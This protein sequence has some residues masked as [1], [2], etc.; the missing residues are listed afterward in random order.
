[1]SRPGAS[2]QEVSVQINPAIPGTLTR[3]ASGADLGAPQI[4]GDGST[5]VYTRFVDNQWDIFKWRD[6]AT[7]AV[8]DDPH[9]D[10]YPAV[11]RDGDTVTW[12]RYSQLDGTDPSGNF[13]IMTRNGCD[14]GPLAATSANE[15]TPAISADGHTVA[16]TYDDPK[17]PIGFDIQTSKD[18][19]TTSATTGWPV[20][21]DP[22]LSGD[23]SRLFFRRKVKL[24]GGD[25]WMQ[26]AGG[27]PKQLT[28]TPDPE[29]D[30]VIDAAG[31]TLV[32]SQ[33]D[34]GNHR[35][36]RFDVASGEQTVLAAEE[37]VDNTNA[38]LSGD[39]SRAAWMRA[40]HRPGQNSD[41]QIVLSE[42]GA[43]V[44]LT[45]DGWNGW[46]KMS[47]DGRVITWVGIDAD[48]TP[49]IY[50]FERSDIPQRGLGA[51]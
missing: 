6:G 28:H 44:P 41:A 51:D 36:L 22:M 34:S 46:P 21:T 32:W 10:L 37:G 29:F 17:S 19:V 42:N 1:M 20:D 23:G 16:W 33:D 30:P 9:S 50:R 48:R 15:M 3:I 24:D 27:E 45:L 43:Q 5:V 35:L 7:E 26:E 39:G 40:D 25:L 8:S 31:N 38:T 12:S 4:S 18:G 11:S 13:D 2:V 49:A 47:E 14:T